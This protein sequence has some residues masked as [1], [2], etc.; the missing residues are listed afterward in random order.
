VSSISSLHRKCLL[1]LMYLCL[2]INLMI[3]TFPLT[4]T[5]PMYTMYN[6]ITLTLYVNCM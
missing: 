2:E 1:Q 5:L 6:N 3:Q 4:T